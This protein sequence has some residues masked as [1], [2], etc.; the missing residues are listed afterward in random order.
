MSVR[1]HISWPHSLFSEQTCDSPTELSSKDHRGRPNS[2]IRQSGWQSVSASD[3][4]W[5]TSGGSHRP[6]G[7]IRLTACSAAGIP[8]PRPPNPPG[9][10]DH[11]KLMTEFTLNSPLKKKFLLA[12]TYQNECT[13]RQPECLMWTNI[14][15]RPTVREYCPRFWCSGGVSLGF[16]PPLAQGKEAVK[17]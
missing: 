13:C 14:Y 3:A 9:S 17:Q 11:N 1:F 7:C 16:P 2:S 15:C 4:H 12:V 8:L 10:Q 6:S 5:P